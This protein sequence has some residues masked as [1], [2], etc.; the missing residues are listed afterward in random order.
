M[1]TPPDVQRFVVAHRDAI[2]GG[3]S[4]EWAYWF[5]SSYRDG[6]RTSDAREFANTMCE[7]HNASW[8]NPNADSPAMRG[9]SLPNDP[10]STTGLSRESYMPD[11][12]PVQYSHQHVSDIHN[13]LTD[14]ATKPEPTTNRDPNPFADQTRADHVFD[15]VFAELAVKTQHPSYPETD[16]LR[17]GEFATAAR[18]QYVEYVNSVGNHRFGPAPEHGTG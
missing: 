15:S 3:Y 8:T 2:N 6:N 11:T 14:W 17:V 5:A 16:W 12:E 18:S 4:P 1:A 9:E 13:Q 10:G 7:H